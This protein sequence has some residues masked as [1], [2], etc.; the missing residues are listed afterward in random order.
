MKLPRI[1][2]KLYVSIGMTFWLLTV[3]FA[4]M[5]I[6]PHIYYR[7]S[8]KTSDVLAATIADTVAQVPAITPVPSKTPGQPT[9]TPTPTKV[10]LPLPDVD[11]SLPSANGLIINKIGVR[12]EIHEGDNWEEILKTGVWR[13]PNFG[14]PEEK[15][16]P[17]ILAAH[18]W[19]Y[20]SWSNS[21]RKLNSFYSLPN[22]AIGDEIQVVWNQR[23]YTYKI[24]AVTTGTAITDYTVD[25]ILYTCQLWNSPVRFFVYANRTN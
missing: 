14:S 19:G 10:V 2:K 22:L 5:P 18:R 7:L 23:P 21:F 17:M 9:P 11:P 1:S 25:L 16:K 3:L 6:W 12:G 4:L 15:G 13:V 20:L 8:P 24:S